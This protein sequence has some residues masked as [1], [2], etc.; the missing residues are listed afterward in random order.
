MVA[1]AEMQKLENC[2]YVVE[3]AKKC[4]FVTIGLQGSDI[5]QGHLEIW[6]KNSIELL[7][8]FL[9]VSF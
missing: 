2:N 1:R 6:T 7:F 3:L 8:H 9:V 5:R 4:D